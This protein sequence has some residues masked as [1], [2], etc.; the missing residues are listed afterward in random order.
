MFYII[1]L[2]IANIVGDMFGI[3]NYSISALMP[4]ILNAL[5]PKIRKQ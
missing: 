4:I 5:S 1:L 2:G 3:V